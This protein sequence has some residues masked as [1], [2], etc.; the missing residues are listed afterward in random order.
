MGLAYALHVTCNLNHETRGPGVLIIVVRRDD[1]R[2]HHSCYSL[3]ILSCNMNNAMHF[4]RCYVNGTEAMVSTLNIPLPTTTKALS[5][6]QVKL[7]LVRTK[8][9]DRGDCRCCKSPES[10]G[11][12]EINFSNL[13]FKLPSSKNIPVIFLK[14]RK[15]STELLPTVIAKRYSII[16]IS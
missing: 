6:V 2:C 1:T 8:G 5:R 11:N 3:L 16:V 9:P 14:L 10:C 4:P 13:N 12:N 7:P 15:K